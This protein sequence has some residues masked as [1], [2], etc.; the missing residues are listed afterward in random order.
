MAQANGRKISSAPTMSARAEMR[1]R[2]AT[3]MLPGMA[4]VN[5]PAPMLSTP[6]RASAQRL[7]RAAPVIAAPRATNPS[8]KA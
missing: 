8:K 4:N 2:M 1:N 3:A 5:T 7:R 6:W